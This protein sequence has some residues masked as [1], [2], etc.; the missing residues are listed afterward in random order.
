MADVSN[1]SSADAFADEYKAPTITIGSKSQKP[2]TART[3]GQINA[4]LRAGGSAGDRKMGQ[5]NKAHQSTDHQRIAKLDRENEVAPPPKISLSVGKAI[6]QGRQAIGLTQKDL[7]TR[8]SE[9][10]SVIQDYES[11]KATPNPQILGKIERILKIKLRG[12]DIG[13]PLGG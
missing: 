2:T 6:M 4:N 7:A 8:M 12:K 5:A 1:G 9:K 3:Q 13:A 10:P 11:S